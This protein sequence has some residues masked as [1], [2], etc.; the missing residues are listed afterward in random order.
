MMI[1][2]ILTISYANIFTY[3]VL[4][5]AILYYISQFSVSIGLF[6]GVIIVIVVIY[7]LNRKENAH[8]DV[9]EDILERKRNSIRPNINKSPIKQ[10]D[11]LINFIFSIQDFYIYNPEAYEN[12]IDNI[13]QFLM[14]YRNVE[15]DEFYSGYQYEIL[16]DRKRD[17]LNH[18]HSII[19]R[20][21]VDMR[22]YDKLNR[23]TARLEDIFNKYMNKVYYNH[24]NKIYHK[25]YTTNIRIITPSNS[26]KPK[27]SYEDLWDK[28]NTYTY[29]MY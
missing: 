2:N 6:M 21:P 15:I 20:V 4:S 1:D 25:G 8:K 28:N 9:H 16:D 14:V 18:L 7:L 24:Q 12:M 22:V 26:P 19:I 23:A 3:V 27:N 10:N 13:E 5:I 29:K 17:A 11:E